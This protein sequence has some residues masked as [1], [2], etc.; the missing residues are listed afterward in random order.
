MGDPGGRRRARGD[1]LRGP[2]VLPGRGRRRTRRH[3]RDRRDRVDDDPRRGGSPGAT[4]RPHRHRQGHRSGGRARHQR[5]G[6]RAGVLRASPDARRDAG[7]G[8]AGPPGTPPARRSPS[9]CASRPRSAAS[10]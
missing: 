9:P 4:R 6:R 3:R 2:R 10:G 8:P 5:P 7:D 1:P